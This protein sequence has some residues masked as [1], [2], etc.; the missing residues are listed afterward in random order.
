MS[1]IF[2]S[3]PMELKFTSLQ[4]SLTDLVVWKVSCTDD[5]FSLL[6]VV[7][8]VNDSVVIPSVVVKASK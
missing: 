7:Y 6:N 3:L 5:R 2:K 8:S 1:L 4:R